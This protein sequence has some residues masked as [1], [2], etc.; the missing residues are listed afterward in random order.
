MPVAQKAQACD[1][2]LKSG[3]KA[4]AKTNFPQRDLIN[5]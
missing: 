4:G 3:L 1:Y 2:H 5:I